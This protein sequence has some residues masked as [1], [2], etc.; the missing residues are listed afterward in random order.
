[1]E[2][3]DDNMLR[4]LLDEAHNLAFG[5]GANGPNVDAWMAKAKAL[6]DDPEKKLDAN[7][8]KYALFGLLRQVK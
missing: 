6:R 8:I 1:M 7:G 5:N 3:P 2:R 4:K